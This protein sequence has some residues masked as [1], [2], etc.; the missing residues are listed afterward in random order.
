MWESFFIDFRSFRSE[1]ALSYVAGE[2]GQSLDTKQKNSVSV[3]DKTHSLEKTVSWA[4]FFWSVPIEGSL[5][6]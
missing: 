1:V 3:I 5:F 2:L 4:S 6:L